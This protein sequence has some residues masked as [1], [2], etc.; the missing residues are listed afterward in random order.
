MERVG[1]PSYVV[2]NYTLPY[3]SVVPDQISEDDQFCSQFHILNCRAI[4][5]YFMRSFIPYDYCIVQ[6]DRK[7]I[8]A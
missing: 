2:I 8:T 7:G 1:I 3:A 5:Q 4:P 6:Q